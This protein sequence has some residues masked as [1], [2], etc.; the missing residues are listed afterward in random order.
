MGDKRYRGKILK[1]L[2]QDWTVAVLFLAPSLIGFAIFYLIPFVM[3]FFYSFQDST[4]DGSFVGF[5]NYNELYASGSFRKAATNTFLFTGI[6]VPLIVVLSLLFA[7]LLNQ[8]LFIRNWLQTAFVLPLVVPVASIVM[9]W[10]I[11]FDWNG[12][13]NVWMQSMHIERIDWMKSDWSMG[14]LVI[15]YTWKNIGYNIILFLAGLQSIP[16]DYYETAD[17]EGAGRFHKLIHITLVYL[18]PTMFFVVLMS[19]INSFKVFRETYLIAG[20]YP[21]DRIYI[22]QHY[23]N[24]MFLSLD[25][26]KLTAA[27]TLMVGCILISVTVMLSIERRFRKF[28]D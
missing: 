8:K 12:T 9:M 27:A 23:M 17:I 18:T 15:V 16:K 11:L 10:Q 28:M 21:H 5:D 14:V 1:L 22:L 20:D 13:V 3:G 25:I 6:S 24:N 4:V 7:I 2:R 26:Q 19:I